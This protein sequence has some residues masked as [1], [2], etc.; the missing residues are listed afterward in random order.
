[1]KRIVGAA[2]VVAALVLCAA[3]MAA[4]L[5]NGS[6]TGTVGSSPLG[7]Q[8]KGTWVLT[9]KSPSYTVAFNGTTVI[10]GTY[11]QG[12]GKITFTD[13]SGKLACPG[14]GVYSYKV[15]GRTVTFKKISDS[16]KCAGRSG[17]LATS[18]TKKFTTSGGGGY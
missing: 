14:K 7:G 3:A 1:M 2:T 11:T 18:F 12:G 13:K 8:L 5:A 9:F 6:Y 15:N 17:V 10:K 4:S 16:S